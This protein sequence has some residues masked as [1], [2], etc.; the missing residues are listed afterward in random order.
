MVWDGMESI[1]WML[2]FS[3][4]VLGDVCTGLGTID[5][6]SAQDV[7]DEAT[8]DAW[9]SNKPNEEASIR[10]KDRPYAVASPYA[11]A[12]GSTAWRMSLAPRGEISSSRAAMQWVTFSRDTRRRIRGRQ[13]GR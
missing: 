12:T 6:L 10:K 9:Q 11:L 1:L 7:V 3:R 4:Y 5:D 8:L 2:C 13:Q